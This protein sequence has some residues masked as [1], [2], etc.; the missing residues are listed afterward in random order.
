[1]TKAISTKTLFLFFILISSSLY[2]QNECLPD[3]INFF[4]Q[5]QIDAFP[6]NY[7]G[8]TVV[9]GDVI[10]RG[11]VQNT[12]ALSVITE[13]QGTLDITTTPNLQSLEGLI[14]L[15]KI[16][17]DLYIHNNAI[18]PP[19]NYLTGLN[20]LT[21]ISG[22]LRIQAAKSII[23]LNGLENLS[24]VGNSFSLI[25]NDNMLS[26][27]GLN[28]INTIGGNLII[29]LQDIT[30]NINN[31]HTLSYVGG[32]IE[33]SENRELN[34]L[35]GLDNIS[36]IGGN[37]ELKSLNDLEVLT[38]FN[39]IDTLPGSFKLWLNSDLHTLNLFSSTKH[40]GGELNLRNGLFDN[41]NSMN[42]L[43]SIGGNLILSSTSM[44]DLGGFSNLQSVGGNFELF[45]N[46]Q[47]SSL[48]YFSNLTSING[49]LS[50][51]IMGSLTRLT[52]LQN[53]DLSSISNLTLQSCS[54]LDY[55]SFPNFCTY[56]ENGGTS[57]ISGNASDC[58]SVTNIE[59]LCGVA[60]EDADMDGY[61]YLF[62]CD[63]NNPDINP[64]ATEIPNNDTDE[65]CNGVTLVIDLDMDGYNSDEDCDDENEDIFP[66]ALEIPNNG[67]DEDC[68]G[69]DLE[70]DEGPAAWCYKATFADDN[71]SEN[72][73]GAVITSDSL[74]YVV[75]QF[76][77]ISI[78]DLDNNYQG[79]WDVDGAAI[80]LTMDAAEN[81]YVGVNGTGNVVVKYD[82]EGNLL[83]TFS[84]WG[85]G[86]DLYVDEEFNLYVANQEDDAVHI[87]DAE[88]NKTD[89]WAYT[90]D[91]GPTLLTADEEGFFYVG[92][93]ENIR[94]YNS[95]GEVVN[96]WFLPLPANTPAL[97]S[98][99][100]LEYNSVDNL[101]YLVRSF[102]PESRIYVYNTDGVFQYEIIVQLSWGHDINFTSDQKMLVAEWAG[103]Q[104]KVYERSFFYLDF[105]PVSASCN[106]VSDGAMDIVVY[107]GCGNLDIELTPNLPIDQL[108]SGD[109]EMTI[110]YPQG[111][112]TTHQFEIT[113]NI[114]FS[115]DYQ[116]ED[117]T[118][119]VANGSI[120]LTVSNGTPEYTY[121][122]DDLNNS[123]TATIENL[124]PGDF[125]V[126]VTDAN[127]CT[128]E[129]TIMI[130]GMGAPEVDL[131]GDGY[132]SD[133]DCDDD[134][135]DI[136]PGI[137]EIPNN[138]VDEDCDGTAQ[139]IDLDMDGFNSSVDCDD[140][141]EEVYPNAPE[142]P[143]NA[144]DENCDGSDYTFTEEDFETCFNK[145]LS[146]NQNQGGS[147]GS[148]VTSD[149]IHC[150]ANP[151]EGLLK[152]DLDNNYLGG[153]PIN[154]T[155]IGLT[156]DSEDHIYIGINGGDNLVE[157]YDID[158][159]L[160]QTFAA[161]GEGEDIFVDEQFNVY[162][163]NQTRGKINVF[164][165]DGNE[166]NSWEFD[167]GNGPTLIT[168]DNNG[169]IY[170]G[171]NEEVHKFTP[172]GDLVNI[173]DFEDPTFGTN[174]DYDN[175]GMEYNP[176][177][178]AL[179]LL[180]TSS[181]LHIF[182]PD[183]F[184]ITSNQVVVG[185]P[186]ALAFSPQQE[187]L[188]SSTSQIKLYVKRLFSIDYRIR[189]VSACGDLGGIDPFVTGGCGST[190]GSITHVDNL[191]LDQLP[192]GA[193]TLSIVYN[194]FNTELV[195][196]TIPQNLP[197]EI[198]STVEA[199]T[200]GLGNGSI[201]LDIT[202]GS[203]EYTYSWDDQNNST[204][205]DLNNLAAGDYTVVV[206]DTDA[207]T[208]TASIT[209]DAVTSTQVIQSSNIK[210]FPNPVS[211]WLVMEYSGEQ[212]PNFSMT[213]YNTAGQRVLNKII[214]EKRT[215]VDVSKYTS[216]LYFL[217]IR[218]LEK[219]AQFT[220]KLVVN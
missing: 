73:Y 147:N 202:G 31:L 117:A 190:L 75:N 163:A 94:K 148:G 91:N 42:Q 196:I 214:S 170:V 107:S 71:F 218:D 106:G 197:I 12:D 120:M 128:A 181:R 44:T 180:R 129:E 110:T 76:T 57:T 72:C 132:F 171:N 17:G 51:R 125:T 182:T 139:V 113:E 64:G 189:P 131:D 192:A 187:I 63:D 150:I 89:E 49:Y 207:C 19:L 161:I 134:N 152:F 119:G 65:D 122:W 144:T 62:D 41:I 52:G 155:A 37:I 86:N 133:V 103:D 8:C 97:T 60:Q 135:P 177:D 209:V 114:S 54:N 115:I 39:N 35:S 194:M 104:I 183:G 109:Y 1:M 43:N 215:M 50:I 78:Y 38:A 201:S 66:N 48:V 210:I 28:S 101:L 140:N 172:Q 83:E 157:K 13:I 20:N 112:I 27:A 138:E 212:T 200:I 211:D 151:E 14:G 6:Q 102:G 156:I 127:G 205:P 154:G 4:S 141:N 169:I 176:V 79:G 95:N 33:I 191:P 58:N 45:N 162:V 116:V 88:G 153:W 36:Y 30:K 82:K 203:N 69:M 137:S 166:I 188:A 23:N 158:G 70:L 145:I 2:S 111:D 53:I 121:L 24:T 9:Q 168:G 47:L 164:A 81:L 7:P 16:G 184:F 118:A 98:N 217:E 198:N 165:P 185:N 204:T 124:N 77:G 216:G 108:P 146:T 61:S 56:L 220:W 10:I 136:N 93:V 26:L 34:D 67:I 80:S 160:L 213:L 55:C 40:I 175:K 32:N 199:A 142:I 149:Y 219:G 208:A 100:G 105:Q 11:S 90:L 130:G 87:F 193:H 68:D 25:T 92:S 123:T 186:T 174:E 74:M 59:N 126:T 179:Y 96:G 178:G 84:E 3:G 85:E 159:N 5:S 99:Y 29:T 15:E 195:E 21:E 167:F 46:T 173:I 206:T 18:D 22:S 143:N